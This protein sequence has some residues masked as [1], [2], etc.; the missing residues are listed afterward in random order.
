M[1]RPGARTEGRLFDTGPLSGLSGV[2]EQMAGPISRGSAEVAWGSGWPW[3]WTPD[4]EVEVEVWSN[5]NRRLEG[6][7]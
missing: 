1:A 7:Q 4:V 3:V 5:G 6:Q 2:I